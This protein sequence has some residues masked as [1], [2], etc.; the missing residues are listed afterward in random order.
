M[1]CQFLRSKSEVGRFKDM[2]NKKP[3]YFRD[4]LD[5]IIDNKAFDIPTTERA[6]KYLNSQ[7]VRFHLRTPSE[8]LRK[9]FTKPGRKKNRMNTGAR[10]N[11]CAGVSNGRIVLWHY[12]PKSWTG[13][14]AADLY[15]DVIFPTLKRTRGVKRSYRILEDND[16][17]GYKSNLAKR[18]KAEKRIQAHVFPRY[19]PDINPLDFSLWQAV[20]QRMLQNTPKKLETVAEYKARLRSTA[21]RLPRVVVSK[22]V[23]N[24]AARIRLVKDAKGGNIA[25]D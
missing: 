5:M 25:Q 3:G 18:A 2:C 8:G 23:N 16:P 1:L 14:V 10:A 4:G 20:T 22:A 13:Q 15:R 9:E 19:S 24:M 7:Q 21:L 17:T 12:L 11:V 6:R